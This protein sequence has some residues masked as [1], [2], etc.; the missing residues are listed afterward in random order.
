MAEGRVRLAL[1]VPLDQCI[2]AA[3]RI[4]RHCEAL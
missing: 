1:V 3:Q 4:R 2:E